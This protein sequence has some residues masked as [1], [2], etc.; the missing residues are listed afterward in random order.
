MDELSFLE[1]SLVCYGLRCFLVL[2]LI[3]LSYEFQSQG[4]C[5]IVGSKP[6][7]HGINGC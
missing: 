2:F 3:K 6:V 4:L 1:I 5:K 7:F